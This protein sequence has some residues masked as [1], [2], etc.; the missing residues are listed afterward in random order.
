ME[1]PEVD[2]ADRLAQR[3]QMLRSVERA[4][5]E[6][7]TAKSRVVP[8]LEVYAAE[9]PRGA[10]K[11]QLKR[12]ANKLNRF[13][14]A[15]YR[16]ASRRINREW[17]PLLLSIARADQPSEA[18]LDLSSQAWG[19]WD[20][21]R[22]FMRGLLYPTLIIV[23]ASLVYSYFRN[24]G[25]VNAP[26]VWSD[27]RGMGAL[28]D[29]IFIARSGF[30]ATIL[31]LSCLWGFLS[32]ELR[33]NLLRWVPVLG[34]AVRNHSWS[35]FIADVS[36]LVR[37]DVPQ[38]EALR[39]AAFA[40]PSRHT[41][42][43]SLDFAAVAETDQQRLSECRFPGLPALLQQAMTPHD[44]A[45]GD[46]STALS[47]LS[48]IYRVQAT[49]RMRKISLVVFPIGIVLAGIT[50]LQAFRSVAIFMTYTSLIN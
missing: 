29:A 4:W 7:L 24:E 8:M 25:S 20:D 12:L 34:R 31:A 35:R 21:A 28:V 17:L 6:V 5:L 44:G 2:E 1:S 42:D 32:Q 27:M 37:S 14:E 50:V 23:G 46:E 3:A 38:M 45:V 26:W 10:R 18:L 15:N 40:S 30:I 11:R 43:A 22:Y 9:L 13:T 36:R 16:D 47:K 19:P 48:E 39:L 33:M 41:R 49:D